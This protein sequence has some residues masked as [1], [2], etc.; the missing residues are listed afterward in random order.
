MLGVYLCCSVALL[1][2]DEQRRQ[3]SGPALLAL[4]QELD[5][6]DVVVGVDVG[7]VDRLQPLQEGREVAAWEG[8]RR[9]MF[10]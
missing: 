8:G 1:A 4:E 2:H 7:D 5:Q 10:S 6:P 3:P 9:P